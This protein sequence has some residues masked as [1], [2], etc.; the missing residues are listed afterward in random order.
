MCRSKLE[1][2]GKWIAADHGG[3]QGAGLHVQV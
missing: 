3:T 2:S 1:P